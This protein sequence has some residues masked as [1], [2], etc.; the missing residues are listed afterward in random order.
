LGVFAARGLK[1]DED[2]VPA[3]P[4][5]PWEYLFYLD[6]VDYGQGIAAA[7]EELQAFTSDI[8]VLGTYPAR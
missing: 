5:R 3:A 6:V 8:R 4:G 1:P 7:L 2:R